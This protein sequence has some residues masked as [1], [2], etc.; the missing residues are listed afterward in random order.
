MQKL[1]GY[2]FTPI[3]YVIFIIAIIIFHPLQV[4][5][6][7]IGGRPWQRRV[8]NYMLFFLTKSLYIAGVHHRFINFDNIPTDR[9]IIVVANHHHIH[10]ITNLNWILRKFDVSFVSKAELNILFI[11]NHCSFLA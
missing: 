9:P 4:I 3:H 11:S 1:L 8:V 2:I 10:D 6:Y 5:A 7:L